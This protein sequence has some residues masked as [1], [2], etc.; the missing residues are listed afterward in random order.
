MTGGDART[1]RAP[2]TPELPPDAK[3]LDLSEQQ[4]AICNM[5]LNE[6]LDALEIARRLDTTAKAVRNQ[7]GRIWEKAEKRKNE[8]NKSVYTPPG[9]VNYCPEQLAVFGTSAQ[10]IAYLHQKMGYGSRQIAEIL[11]LK[12]S[13]VR[14]VISRSRRQNMQRTFSDPVPIPARKTPDAALEEAVLLDGAKMFY[15]KFVSGTN[16]AP[17]REVL[18]G[19]HLTAQGGRQ[20]AKVVLGDR[21]G[22]VKLLAE[23][24][25][26]YKTRTE[27][28]YIDTDDAYTRAVCGKILKEHFTQ[29]CAGHFKPKD[30]MALDL[31]RQAILE[32]MSAKDAGAS[33]TESY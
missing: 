4:R 30:K 13:T 15:N 32:G 5:V 20:G 14:N 25:R 21:A 3:T 11:N 1:A 9:G 26:A 28:V 19:L 31:L 27:I 33:G 22:I 17:A 2:Q 7:I 23:L 12:E 24:S 6:H 8:T 18:R 29:V 16:K 10:K